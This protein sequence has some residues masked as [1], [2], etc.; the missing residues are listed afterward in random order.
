MR[1]KRSIISR[2]IHCCISYK[3]YRFC[4]SRGT[5]FPEGSVVGK[6]L[7]SQV[8]TFTKKSWQLSHLWVSRFVGINVQEWVRQ[9][10]PSSPD[11]SSLR[12]RLQKAHSVVVFPGLHVDG[13]PEWWFCCG[14]LV[15]AS[16]GTAGNNGDLCFPHMPIR[17]EIEVMSA[18]FTNIQS[19]W[20]VQ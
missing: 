11:L 19:E 16:L 8:E 3:P 4:S 9:A 17:C 14:Y 2:H 6:I 18:V 13:A 10:I 7:S 12:C 1:K 20:R 15:F 5:V